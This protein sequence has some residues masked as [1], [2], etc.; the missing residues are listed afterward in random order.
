MLT[1]SM[2]DISSSPRAEGWR[3]G[4]LQMTLHRPTLP[5]KFLCSPDNKRS[6]YMHPSNVYKRG[7]R[8]MIFKKKR[9]KERQQVEEVSG[10][11]EEKRPCCQAIRPAQGLYRLFAYQ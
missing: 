3:Q 2:K 1:L 6:A 8:E 11:G 10:E 4:L 7:S 5:T 9:K